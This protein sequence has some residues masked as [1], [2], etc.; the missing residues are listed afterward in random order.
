VQPSFESFLA[1]ADRISEQLQELREGLRKAIQVATIDPEMALT[2]ARKVLEYVIRDVYARR[3]NATPGT[4]PLENLLQRLAKDGY[5]PARLNAYANSVRMLGNVGTHTFGECVSPMDVYLCLNQLLPVLD[6]YFETDNPSGIAPPPVETAR[7]QAPSKELSIAR[8]R[9]ALED[10]SPEARCHALRRVGVHRLGELVDRVVALLA[11]DRDEEVRAAAAWA[12]DQL[13]EPN[14]MPAL[15]EAIQ[16]PSWAV[17]S[18]AGWG[19]VHLGRSARDEV[20]RLFRETENE[21]AKE[22]ARLVLERL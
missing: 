20:Q 17:R 22:M 8:V 5:I 18:N 1:L 19:L 14:T 9:S 10:P 12:L 4:Q 7:R 13:Q 16:D 6:W 3:Y 21:D 11:R 2:R 15:I